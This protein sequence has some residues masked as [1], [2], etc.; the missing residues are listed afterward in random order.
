M[1]DREKLDKMFVISG[2]N[3]TK[4]HESLRQLGPPPKRGKDHWNPDR[5]TTGYCYVVSEVV[6]YAMKSNTVEHKVFRLNLENGE[7]HWFIRLGKEGDG[8]IID[9]TA[10]Q[11]DDMYEY[12]KA[13]RKGFNK[14]KHMK[15]GMSG[16]AEELAKMMQII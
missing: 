13:K 10:D 16:K 12:K 4:L 5:P 1:M 15:Y 11:I 3:K 7:S 8:E 9:L 6:S 2:I 14:N